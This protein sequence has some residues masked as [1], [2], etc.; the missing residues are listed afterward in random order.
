MMSEAAEK[1]GDVG[2]GCQI[3]LIDT[4][5]G[6]GCAFLEEWS[7]PVFCRGAEYLG[8]ERVQMIGECA[9]HEF[10]VRLKER[11][12]DVPVVPTC[13]KC[14]LAQRKGGGKGLRLLIQNCFITEAAGGVRGPQDHIVAEFVAA[15]GN[16]ATIEVS[17][18][19]QTV[20]FGLYGFID[21]AACYSRSWPIQASD[22]QDSVGRIEQGGVGCAVK[23]IGERPYPGQI[24]L[25]DRQAGELA[26]D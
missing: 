16:S 11:A 6:G 10:Q 9:R 26:I 20:T 3:W 24:Q 4:S 13:V 25:A 1:C 21:Q 8:A 7:D 14:D 12:R 23:G 2:R 5:Q 19:P 18:P 15:V 22:H 17:S